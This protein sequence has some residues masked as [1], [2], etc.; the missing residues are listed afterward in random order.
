MNVNK[1]TNLDIQMKALGF[2]FD[3]LSLTNIENV[4]VTFTHPDLPI[5]TFIKV[6]GL[7]G[8]LATFAAAAQNIPMSADRIARSYFSIYNDIVALTNSQ[9]TNIWDDLTSGSPIKLS[10]NTGPN[11][12]FVFL[13]WRIAS[14]A[15]LPAATITDMK[16]AAA[17]YYVQDNPRYLITPLFDATINIP[18]DVATTTIEI[19]VLSESRNVKP[20]PNSKP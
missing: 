1:L 11:S 8:L 12:G 19:L 2:T 13:L 18:G 17:T 15:S 7:V 14:N 10:Q 6:N 3:G 4:L 20:L 5:G 16:I 9:K